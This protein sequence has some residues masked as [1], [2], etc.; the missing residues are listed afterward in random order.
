MKILDMIH[1]VLSGC[2]V[3]EPD[4]KFQEGSEWK[5]GKSVFLRMD[6]YGA[7]FRRYDS[8]D[9]GGLRIS[10]PYSAQTFLLAMFREGHIK[11]SKFMVSTAITKDPYVEQIIFNITNLD[12][13]L[14]ART[15]ELHG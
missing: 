1:Y 9:D 15:I 2:E 6:D 14:V 11:A 4:R 7:Y 10:I 12:G 5:I 8:D 13:S 3:S